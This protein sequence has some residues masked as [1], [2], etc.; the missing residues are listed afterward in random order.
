M[1][2]KLEARKQNLKILTSSIERLKDLIKGEDEEATG[3]GVE[4]EVDEV[5]MEVVSKT[6][7]ITVRSSNET[8]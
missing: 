6:T 1:K 7:I 4:V 5:P 2:L 8:S 3:S